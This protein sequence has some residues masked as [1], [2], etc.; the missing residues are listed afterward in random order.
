MK[1]KKVTAL[2]SNQTNWHDNLNC[3]EWSVKKQLEVAMNFYCNRMSE[4]EKERR[5]FWKELHEV[6]KL[7]PKKA[8]AILN[9]HQEASIV[10]K[11]EE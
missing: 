8:Y 6:Y 2:T 11:V 7:D 9:E 4:I 1:H 5:I 10:E 3:D